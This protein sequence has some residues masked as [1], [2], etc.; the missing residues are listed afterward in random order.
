MGNE[1]SQSWQGV[2]TRASSTGTVLI[3][4]DATRCSTQLAMEQRDVLL[5]R[6]LQPDSCYPCAWKHKMYFLLCPGDA[7]GL[8]S[9]V[10]GLKKFFKRKRE[11]WTTHNNLMAR[12]GVFFSSWLVRDNPC[13]RPL[14]TVN[15]VS[16]LQN[17]VSLWA[18]SP[19]N[20]YGS[21]EMGLIFT[22]IWPL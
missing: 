16:P 11:K 10:N 7:S 18:S 22:S 6:R 19:H 1:T 4:C 15:S 12:S 9:E 5:T 17:S 3:R 8:N 2:L 13:E 14:Q 20:P 21:P